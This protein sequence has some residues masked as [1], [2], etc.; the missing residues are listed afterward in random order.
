VREDLIMGMEFAV[1]FRGDH[2]HVVLSGESSVDSDTSRDYWGTLRKI[3]EEYD[4]KKVLV[5]G[6][7]P[8]G[9]RKPAEV[10][11][12]GQRT[13]IVP[14]L[15]LAY[16]LENY[17]PTE[18]SELYEAVAASKGVRVKFFDD[19]DDALNWLRTNAPT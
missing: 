14:N 13:A 4:C 17:Q 6:L 19:A 16:H 11:E 1:T 10:L 15:W 5:E 3:C 8:G 9:E 12:A 18:L 2:V 7:A